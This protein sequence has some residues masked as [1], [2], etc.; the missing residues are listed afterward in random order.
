M[1]DKKRLPKWVIPVA[2]VAV[3]AITVL[4][5]FLT[6]VFEPKTVEVPDI[7]NMNVDEAQALLQQYELSVCITQ[8]EINDTV[9]EN[10]VL[11]QSPAVGTK[12]HKGGTVNVT[13]SEK[14]VEIDIPDVVNY[15]KEL[16]V[17]VL[18]NAGFKVEVKEEQT[19]KFADGSVISQSLTGKGKTGSVITLVVA[20]N[21]KAEDKKM[22]KVPSVTGKNLKEASKI[23]DGKLYIIVAE[24]QYS[25]SVKK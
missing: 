1:K 22:I 4:V 25:D 18:Q 21:G 9:D 14:S 15:K 7:V 20:R 8:K 13:I 10:T 2:A 3:V 11:A 6:G 12:I 17:T 5:L 16:A 19:D 24:E 23:L